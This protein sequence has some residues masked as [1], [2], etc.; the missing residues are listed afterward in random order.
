MAKRTQQDVIKELVLALVD[1]ALKYDGV[2]T[3]EV[4]ALAAELRGKAEEKS[5]EEAAG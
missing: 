2:L 1:H 3:P 4:I 5:G